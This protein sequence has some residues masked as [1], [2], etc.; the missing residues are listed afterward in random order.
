MSNDC[1]IPSTIDAFNPYI[2]TTGAYLI[3]GTPTNATRL[4]IAE[5]EVEKWIG[6]GDSW[7]PLFFKYSD[8]KV[9][10][11]TAIKDQLNDIIKN[12]HQFNQDNHLLDRIAASLN[13]NILDMETFNIKKG[14]LKKDTRTVSLSAINELV[15]AFV[16]PIGGGSFTIKCHDSRST[17]AGIIAEADSVQY[18]YLVGKVPP[19]SPLVAGLTK[20]ISTKAAFTLPLGADKSGE[21]LFIYFRWYLTKYPNLAGPWCSLITSLIL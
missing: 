5:T 16:Q 2:S 21:Q 14:V 11:T 1:R 10:R 19:E 7:Y 17:R 9:K 4:G 8:K 13:V 20:E 3:D 18:I 15:I 12:C 6:F